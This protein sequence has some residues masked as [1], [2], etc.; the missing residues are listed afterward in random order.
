MQAA[1]SASVPSSPARDAATAASLDAAL[2]SALLRFFVAVA[3]GAARGWSS[4]AAAPAMPP[5]EQVQTRRQLLR[6]R[7]LSDAQ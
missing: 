6:R 5:L 2:P 1:G 4:A 3:R 7:T